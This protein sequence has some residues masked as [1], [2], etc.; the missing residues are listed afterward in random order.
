M[1]P[2]PCPGLADRVPRQRLRRSEWAYL[3]LGQR[4]TQ[5][6]GGKLFL[7]YHSVTTLSLFESLP[8]ARLA[9]RGGVSDDL[10]FIGR[11]RE[12]WSAGV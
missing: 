4:P 9:S 10:S 7:Y 1:E 11:V 3:T 2:G 5:L 8:L 12:T 6:W